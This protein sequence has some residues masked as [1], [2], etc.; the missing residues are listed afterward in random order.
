[1]WYIDSSAILK[2]IKPE[3]ESAALIKKL[4]NTLIASRI[5][6]VEVTRTIIRYEP[7]LLDST[8][9][10]LADIQMVP[11]EDSII[12]IAENLP[13]FIN[14]RSLDS[15]HI[16]SALAIKNVLKGIITYDKEMVIAANALGFKTLSPGL[17][18]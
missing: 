17:K 10:V 4:P 9:D 2:L 5:S 12:T 18:L 13:Q 7:D 14:L 1:M 16:A 15:L 3:K 6:R 11:V 8:Y